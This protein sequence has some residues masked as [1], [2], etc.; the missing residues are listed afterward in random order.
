MGFI[1]NSPKAFS[2]VVAG[3]STIKITKEY[4]QSLK[5]LHTH[6]LPDHVI[7]H[8]IQKL[9][10]SKDPSDIKHIFRFKDGH[11]TENTA[12]NKALLTN[13][14]KKTNFLGIDQHGN[15]WFAENLKDGSQLWAEARA[16]TGKI[17]NGGKNTHPIQFNKKTG[18]SAQS[19]PGK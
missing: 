14:A 1:I 19:K 2:K 8:V 3:T 17:F 5:E 12:T 11:F 16:N 15:W 6:E 4:L 18:L 10:L 9:E 7:D 13:T